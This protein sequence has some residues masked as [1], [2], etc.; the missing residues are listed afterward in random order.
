MTSATTRRIRNDII[1]SFFGSSVAARV[2]PSSPAPLHL[3]QVDVENTAPQW[4]TRAL[5]SRPWLPRRQKVEPLQRPHL[6][7]TRPGVRRVAALT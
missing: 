3:R 6:L 4:L 5:S 2:G 7:P 1:R